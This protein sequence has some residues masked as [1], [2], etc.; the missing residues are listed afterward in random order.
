MKA[1]LEAAGYE[2]KG[3]IH[4]CDVVGLRDGEETAVVEMKLALNLDVLLQAVDRRRLRIWSISRSLPP[5]TP[6][7]G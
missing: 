1:F 6:R 7:R 4:G 5:G 3:E 2:A